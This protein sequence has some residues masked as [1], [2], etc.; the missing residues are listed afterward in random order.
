MDLQPK[1]PPRLPEAAHEWRSPVAALTRFRG[2][3]PDSGL[4]LVSASPQQ[5]EERWAVPV[6]DYWL[7]VAPELGCELVEWSTPCRIPN[8]PGWM[9]GVTNVRGTLVPIFDL[10]P[11]LAEAGKKADGKPMLFVLGEGEQAGALVVNGLPYRQRLDSRLAPTTPPELPEPLAAR[12]KSA[13]R[14][15]GEWLLDCD[16]TG[17]LRD[18]GTL[19]AAV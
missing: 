12:V 3:T 17:A 11:L 6:V 14:H 10:H 7:M 1:A 19:A 13:Y 15:N 5:A 4:P 18:L 2:V 16:L 8:T 9:R